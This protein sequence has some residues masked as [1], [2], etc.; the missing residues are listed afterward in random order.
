MNGKLSPQQQR[1]E[2]GYSFPYHYVPRWEDGRFTQHF[3]WWWGYRYLGGIQVVLAE[4]AKIG[5]QS[6]V[7]IGCGDGRFLREAAR[8]FP[9]AELLGIDYSQ[10]AI[11]I[12]QAFNPGL[13]YEVMD[14]IATPP[15]R[16]FAIATLIEVLEHIPPT[17]IQDFV[18]AVAGLIEDNGYLV[19]TVPHSNKPVEAKHYQH[20]DMVLLRRTLES[21]FDEMRFIPFDTLAHKAP[22]LSFMEKL[23][24]G[25]GRYWLITNRRLLGA[26]F[27]FYLRNHLYCESETSAGR[28][29]LVC[30]KKSVGHEPA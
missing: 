2:D 7:D 29:A 17:Q 6:L 5:V 23:L 9:G 8:F 10:R 19:M 12:A 27:R 18:A 16:R 4:L 15:P 30:R 21:S 20:F 28:I 3:H 14:I 26:F 1:Q 24:G 22:L 25:K 13:S 11:S